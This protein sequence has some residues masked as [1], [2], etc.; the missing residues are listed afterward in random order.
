LIDDLKIGNDLELLSVAGISKSDNCSKEID[1]GCYPIFIFSRQETRGYY[2][3]VRRL[4]RTL[5]FNCRL[6][7]A[8][9]KITLKQFA[10][11]SYKPGLV[12]ASLTSASLASGSLASCIK[13]YKSP[14]GDL[15]AD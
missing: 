13:H 8:R 5:F 10:L 7:T 1:G 14:L 11:I 15:G 6:K 9:Q 4:E 3:Q 2:I 12:S